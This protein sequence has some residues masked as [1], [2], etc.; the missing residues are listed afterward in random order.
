MLVTGLLA[1]AW[2]GMWMGVTSKKVNAAV[3]KTLVFVK[4]FPFMAMMFVNWMLMFV[5]FAAG[6]RWLSGTNYVAI[7]VPELITFLLAIGG[8]VAFTLLSRRKLLVN[9]REIVARAAGAATMVKPP[10]LPASNP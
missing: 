5:I 3:M 2:F 7:W 10:P 6:S 9:F 4:V 8:D 1:V